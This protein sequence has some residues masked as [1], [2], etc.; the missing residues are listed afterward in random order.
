MP[1][2]PKSAGSGCMF[3]PHP[4]VQ[5]ACDKP[6]ASIAGIFT[7]VLSKGCLSGRPPAYDRRGA[8]PGCRSCSCELE[9]HLRDVKQ[10]KV[11]SPADDASA[12]HAG[13]T[14][15]SVQ[16]CTLSRNGRAGSGG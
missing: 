10:M 12:G 5:C 9:R 14:T 2:D 3:M 15:R 8:L 1:I 7:G 16:N 13:V 11:N 6:L 4:A